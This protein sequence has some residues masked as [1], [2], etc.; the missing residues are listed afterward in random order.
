[1]ESVMYGHIEVRNGRLKLYMFDKELPPILDIGGA[2]AQ[3]IAGILRERFDS[4]RVDGAEAIRIDPF[5]VLPV[6]VWVVASVAVE[7]S[8]DLL[9][10][11]LTKTPKSAV[12]LIFESEEPGRAY[13]NGGPMIRYWK[14]RRV[15]KIIVDILR[16]EGY[17]V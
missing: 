11:L 10:A 5:R 16:F 14:L 6:L 12:N 7:P 2:R 9:E 1:M 3:K 4:Y 13:I 8:T 17:P 15:A